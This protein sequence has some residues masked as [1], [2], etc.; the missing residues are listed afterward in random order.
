MAVFELHELTPGQWPTTPTNDWLIPSPSLHRWGRR[1]L[2]YDMFCSLGT[3]E[4]FKGLT[5]LVLLVLAAHNAR[6]HREHTSASSSDASPTPAPTFYTIRFIAFWTLIFS[7][8]Y[9]IWS[10]AARMRLVE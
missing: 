8:F 7:Y 6:L 3:Y 2:L 10:A 5:L 9:E 1:V 4:R